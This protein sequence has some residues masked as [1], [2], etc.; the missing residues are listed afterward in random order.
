MRRVGTLAFAL[1]AVAVTTFV[2]VL[3][4]GLLGLEEI[5]MLYLLAIM[6]VAL[7]TVVVS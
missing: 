1:I 2:A 6:V 7:R 4:R 3:L 5:V